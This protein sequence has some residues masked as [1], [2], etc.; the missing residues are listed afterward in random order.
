M[1]FYFSGAGN[2]YYVAKK[3]SETLD[4]KIVSIA[5]TLRTKDLYF[6]VTTDDSIGFVF[7]VH[8]WGVPYIVTQFL[9]QMHLKILPNTY[10]WI[11]L[12]CGGSTGNTINMAKDILKK[13]NI[14]VNASYSIQMTDV[15]VPLFKVPSKEVLNERLIKVNGFIDQVGMFLKNKD[16]GDID[17]YRSKIAK[18]TTTT[19][20]PLYS[21]YRNTSKFSVND[22]CIACKKCEKICP[23]DVIEVYEGKPVWKKKKCT[24]CFACVH[25][26]PVSAIDYGKVLFFFSSKGQGRYK[27]PK[28]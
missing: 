23:L 7:P 5:D 10:V 26:C 21:H 18:L 2:S 3:L 12:T 13:Q 19:M 9:E 11:V 17:I 27:A 24:I 16:I 22:A 25:V 20:Y 1:I 4:Q 8:F 14:I 15:F 6:D 28:P